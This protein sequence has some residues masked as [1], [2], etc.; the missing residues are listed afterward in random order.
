M[1]D[2]VPPQKLKTL[3]VPTE[4]HCVVLVS[5]LKRLDGSSG[6]GFEFLLDS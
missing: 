1:L 2:E 5:L 6:N 3:E 4:E